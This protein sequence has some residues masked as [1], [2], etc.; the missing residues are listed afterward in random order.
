MWQRATWHEC[1]S[2][3]SQVSQQFCRAFLGHRTNGVPDDDAEMAAT[4][5]KGVELLRALALAVR[6]E[7]DFGMV[8]KTRAV[9]G[10][11]KRANAVAADAVLTK[12][13]RGYEC[14]LALEGY[15]PLVLRDALNK[16]AHADPNGADF[17]VGAGNGAHELLLFGKD[18]DSRWFAAISLPQ[19]VTVIH[20][21]PDAR[22]AP[23]MTQS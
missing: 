17:Y 12:Q 18:R 5:V 14:M 16:I 2:E 4:S 1:A 13:N 20:S 6:S 3:L 19:L 23:T 15:D 7:Q 22:L 9:V 10:A 11:F 21:L 8:P